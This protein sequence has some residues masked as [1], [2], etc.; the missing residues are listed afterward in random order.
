MSDEMNEIYQLQ[1]LIEELRNS[2]IQ[3]ERTVEYLENSKIRD[4]E[5]RIDDNQRHIED[6]RRSAGRHW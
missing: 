6:I 2:I 3:L 5:F 4:L 1:A